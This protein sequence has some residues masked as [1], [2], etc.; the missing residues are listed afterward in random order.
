MVNL[1]FVEAYKEFG[2]G[3]KG[4]SKNVLQSFDNIKEYK[5]EN[6]VLVYIKTKNFEFSTFHENLGFY[7]VVYEEDS[8]QLFEREKYI[9]TT[10]GE[11]LSID[12][13][14]Y[15]SYEA[16]LDNQELNPDV[17]DE[18]IKEE[19]LLEEEFD[20]Y[21]EMTY[22]NM[23]IK[24]YKGKIRVEISMANIN[25]AKTKTLEIIKEVEGRLGGDR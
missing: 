5:E 3:V 2:R 10:S 9:I 8:A 4:L 17:L 23:N 18:I 19:L 11:L 7:F 25:D 13:W 20:D 6:N 16:D 14:D 1:R 21:L 12:K 22:E 24:L 15:V